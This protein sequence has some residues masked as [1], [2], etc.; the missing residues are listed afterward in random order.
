[1]TILSLTSVP[2]RF[3]QLGPV[4]ASLVGQGA[5]RVILALARQYTRFPGPVTPPALPEGVKII[6]SED[7]GPA[8]KILAAQ[9]AY[10]DAEIVYC[11]DDCLYA[12]GWLSALR[13]G[14]GVRAGSVF[15]ARRL[16]RQG[17]VVAQGFAGVRLPAGFAPFTPPPAACLLADDLWLSAEM[18]ARGV[19][20]TS[21]RAARAHVTTLKS[22][23]GL[24]DL[25]RRDT[26][27]QA[28]AIVHSIWRV[29]PPT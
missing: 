27:E 5:D 3:A 22:S 1:M 9:R 19:S 8:T 7:F 26:Y 25:D 16:K 2:P 13:D 20:I 6:W 18:A 17:G 23:H 24:Q 28:V 10:P 12:P 11:D 15:D 21:S 4:L 14:P 29:W